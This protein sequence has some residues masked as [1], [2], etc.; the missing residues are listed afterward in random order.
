MHSSII[1]WARN[2]WNCG[3]LQINSPSTFDN[4]GNSYKV[5]NIVDKAGRLVPEKFQ[6]ESHPSY[7]SSLKPSYLLF[8]VFRAIH[9]GYS[10]DEHA[11]RNGIHNWQ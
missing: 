6:S 9:G 8:R 2:S 11:R 7:N 10:V 4:K 5:A 3:Y 1:F